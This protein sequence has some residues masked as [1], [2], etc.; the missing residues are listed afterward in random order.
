MVHVER[1]AGLILSRHFK[2]DS[3]ADQESI[4]RLEIREVAHPVDEKIFREI[5]WLERD[6]QLV[7][8]S[9]GCLASD[10]AHL[11]IVWQPL[12]GLLVQIDRSGVMISD[13]PEWTHD[14]F[15]SLVLGDSTCGSRADRDNSSLGYRRLTHY[16]ALL[17]S[18]SLGLVLEGPS[19]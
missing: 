14:H 2:L 16:R 4:A 9:L 10:D 11:A 8:D 13:N 5:A 18:H 17:R 15:G 19:P 6:P 3:R 1:H 12:A 7:R